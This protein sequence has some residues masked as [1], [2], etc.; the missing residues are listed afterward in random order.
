MV[1]Q[2]LN[3]EQFITWRKQYTS[4][5]LAK[6]LY[7]ALERNEVQERRHSENIESQEKRIRYVKENLE[8]YYRRRIRK[9]KEKFK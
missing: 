8:K 2:I 9:L 1:T 7:Q 4:E 5:C 3:E 6:L